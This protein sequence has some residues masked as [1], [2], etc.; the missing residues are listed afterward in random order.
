MVW[1]MNGRLGI[2]WHSGGGLILKLSWFVQ[3]LHVTWYLTEFDAPRSTHSYQLISPSQKN[4]KSYSLCR[5][6]NEVRLCLTWRSI[7]L[8][9]SRDLFLTSAP[10]SVRVEVLAVPKNMKLLAIPLF[11]LYDNAARCV[12]ITRPL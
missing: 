7:F 3:L 5:C 8:G 10:I 11:E 9:C 4:A 2:V 12:P 6:L 1:I